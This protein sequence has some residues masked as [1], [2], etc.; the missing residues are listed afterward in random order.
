MR[1]AMIILTVL[2]LLG[3]LGGTGYY[4]YDKEQKRQIAEQMAKDSIRRARDAEIAHWKAVEQARRDSAAAYEKTHAPE[5]LMKRME[6]LLK[7]EIL[8]NRNHVGGKNWTERFNIL[9]EQCQNVVAYAD[10]PADSIFRSFSFKGMMGDSI[11]I[12]GDSIM[13]A[14]KITPDSAYVDVHFDIGDK[15]PEGQDVAFKLKF[16]GG[17]WIIDDFTFQYTDG[18]YYTESEEMK[19]FIE[20]FG[21]AEATK[22]EDDE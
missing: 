15:H 11:R 20:T 8:N 16:I 13:R 14:Y 21:R 3:I 10:H 9:R 4:F 22:S 5:V 1:K 2:V 6:Q 17:Q 12:Q 19:W 18:E 7:D